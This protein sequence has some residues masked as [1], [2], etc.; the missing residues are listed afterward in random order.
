LGFPWID[1]KGLDADIA[2]FSPIVNEAA[3]LV[4]GASGTDL[5]ALLQ[6]LESP[7]LLDLAVNAINAAS[8][9]K[10]PTT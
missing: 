4:P 5:V 8:G 6:A 10:A 1:A 2:K 3:S 7:S 9:A